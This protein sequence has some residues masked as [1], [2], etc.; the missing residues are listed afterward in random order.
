ME[1][2]ECCSSQMIVPAATHDQDHQPRCHPPPPG[3][4]DPDQFRVS[5]PLLVLLGTFFLWFGWYGFNGGS[6]FGLSGGN[7]VIAARCCITTTCAAAAGGLTAL[8]VGNL[9]AKKNDLP[10]MCNGI[11]GGL[12]GKRDV[13]GRFS[14]KCG[15]P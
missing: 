11:L 14:R 9:V 10:L 5:N 8:L 3:F 15:G 7:D 4:S 1:T 13:E 12:V 2:V 6:T